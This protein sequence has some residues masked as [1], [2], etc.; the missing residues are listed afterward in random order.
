LAVKRCVHQADIAVTAQAK[1]IRDTPLNQMVDYDF[2]AFLVLHRY[3][4]FLRSYSR[5]K[6]E[7]DVAPFADVA[8]RIAGPAAPDTAH[9]PSM[10]E[11]GERSDN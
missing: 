4:P 6:T 3:S 9:W 1:K 8:H 2:G 7:G 10:L 11:A 5:S